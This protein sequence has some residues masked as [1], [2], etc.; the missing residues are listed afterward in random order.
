MPDLP[1]DDRRLWAV[2]YAK[3]LDRM[4]TF[5]AAILGAEPAIDDDEDHLRLEWPAGQLIVQ[6]IPP[7][8][9][10]DIEI[11]NP[12]E[13]RTETPLKVSFPVADI[14][15]ARSLAAPLGGR[16]DPPE[17]EWRYRG[18]LICDGHDPEGNVVQL[19]QL[20]PADS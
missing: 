6:A 3:D 8:I 4:A 19:R 17:A 9:A 18:E 16:I 13:R 10:D 14:A 2:I 7:W 1:S 20:P 11:T 5:Y 12:P 15:E